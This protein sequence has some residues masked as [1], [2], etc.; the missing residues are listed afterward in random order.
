MYLRLQGDVRSNGAGLGCRQT[1]RKT[2]SNRTA[3][4]R[5]RATSRRC[6]PI[7]PPLPAAPG[8]TPSATSSRWCGWKRRA[9]RVRA[10]RWS[11][12]DHHRFDAILHRA[13]RLA[14]GAGVPNRRLPDQLGSFGSRLRPSGWSPP[15]ATLRSLLPE[16]VGRLDAG[17]FECRRPDGSDLGM[18]AGQNDFRRFRCRIPSIR[19]AGRTS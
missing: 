16:A 9:P 12:A 5:S 6:P 17:F 2:V 1:I 14:V 11:A 4:R 13:G 15:K 7:L 8:S 10:G 18:G 19:F 3:A